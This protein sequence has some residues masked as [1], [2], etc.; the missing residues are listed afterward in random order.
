MRR[1]W[2][3]IL[4]LALIA[5]GAAVSRIARSGAVRT[6]PLSMK[7]YAFNGVNPRIT[8]RAGERVRFVL[9]N[10]ET[11]PILHNFQVPG[12]GI[13]CGDALRPGERR[14][15][16]VTA[17]GPGTFPYSCCTHRGMGGK[18]VVLPR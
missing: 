3:W 5:V 2:I 16:L 12:I 15:I 1:T 9:T 13:S 8:L 7:G 17:P 10:D 18:L 11:T 6:I 4:L 14:E